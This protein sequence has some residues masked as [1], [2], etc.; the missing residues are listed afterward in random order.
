MVQACKQMM[1]DDAL[2][3]MC[4]L[5][6]NV[7][8]GAERGARQDSGAPGYP[9]HFPSCTENVGMCYQEGTGTT[10]IPLWTVHGCEPSA[11]PVLQDSVLCARDEIRS[12]A[13]SPYTSFWAMLGPL[14]F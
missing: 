5:S 11:F 14:I 7:L 13:C 3:V 12:R 1:V 9:R 2:A 10:H 8:N 6:S 4:V